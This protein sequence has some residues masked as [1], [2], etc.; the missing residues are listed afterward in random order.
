M[1]L[2][3]NILYSDKHTID[4]KK[5]LILFIISILIPQSEFWNAI[6]LLKIYFKKV[7]SHDNRIENI[8]KNERPKF[9]LYKIEALPYPKYSAPHC[10]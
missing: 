10:Y 7:L 8:I 5:K 9:V 2:L 1:L 6:V 3:V 4:I